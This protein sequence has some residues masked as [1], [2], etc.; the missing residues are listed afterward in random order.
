MED[1]NRTERSVAFDP[2]ERDRE[3]KRKAARRLRV[4]LFA[5]D[6]KPTNRGGVKP[7]NGGFELC[8]HSY[9]DTKYITEREVLIS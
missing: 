7:T 9:Y 1:Q 4:R 8:H 2:L 6:N 5:R 3:R